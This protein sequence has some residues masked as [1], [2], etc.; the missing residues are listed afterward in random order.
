[1]SRAPSWRRVMVRG[2]PV[3]DVGVGTLMGCEG[4]RVA[5][6]AG[7]ARA[8]RRVIAPAHRTALTSRHV[9]GLAGSIQLRRRTNSPFHPR[10]PPPPG[11]V[12]RTAQN[13]IADLDLNRG[14]LGK[15]PTDRAAHYGGV[16]PPYC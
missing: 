7:R 12:A 14:R 5:T 11:P 16:I 15:V 1:M 3:G 8:T 6:H 13:T 10:G 4:G 2:P 9:L